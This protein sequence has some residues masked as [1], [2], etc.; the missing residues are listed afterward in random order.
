MENILENTLDKDDVLSEGN[1]YLATHC[2]SLGSPLG[3][4]VRSTPFSSLLLASLLSVVGHHHGR[5]RVY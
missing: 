3:M 5:E 2:E 1:R 4:R